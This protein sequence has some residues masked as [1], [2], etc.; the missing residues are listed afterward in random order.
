MRAAPARRRRLEG[1]RCIMY[2]AD[3]LLVQNC[4]THS[5]RVV[6][7]APTGCHNDTPTDTDPSPPPVVLESIHLKIIAG[8]GNKAYSSTSSASLR[9]PKSVFGAD[10][11]VRLLASWSG[12]MERFFKHQIVRYVL[13]RP[14]LSRR[15]CT[16][17]SFGQKRVRSPQSDA[18]ISS[19]H[20]YSPPLRRLQRLSGALFAKYQFPSRA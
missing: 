8:P 15:P 5:H 6:Q 3:T 16:A 19:P 18:S 13:R 1:K 2:V 4:R 20:I 11:D 17:R 9:N 10:A 7:L 14:N 12:L